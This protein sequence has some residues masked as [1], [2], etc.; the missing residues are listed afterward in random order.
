MSLPKP[1][2]SP[3]APRRLKRGKPPARKAGVRQR[4]PRRAEVELLD[5]K[6]SLAVRFLAGFRCEKCHRQAQVAH[7]ARTKASH[8]EL[9]HQPLN[10][11]SLCVPCHGL[12]HAYPDDFK[13][14]LLSVRPEAASLW[15]AA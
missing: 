2:K 3:R 11:V 7:H 13:A 15:A 8:P 9:R 1:T 10:G 5:E 6:W 14:W 4:S 12:A